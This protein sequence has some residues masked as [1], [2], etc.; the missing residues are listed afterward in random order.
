MDSF[1]KEDLS[2]LYHMR[3]LFSDVDFIEI[4][5][6]FPTQDLTIPTV[7]VEASTIEALKFELGSTDRIHPRVWYIDIFA[8]NKSQRDDFGYRILHDLEDA[9]IDVLNFDEGFPPD[10]SPT[11]IGCL[12]VEDISYKPMRIFPELVDKLYYRG[13][14]MFTTIYSSI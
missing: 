7:S 12:N 4:V 11:K 3:D 6:G 9:C 8:K 13:Q 10:Q 14:V 2:V 1:R 5:D